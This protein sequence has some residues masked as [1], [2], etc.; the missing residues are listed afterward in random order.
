M[1]NMSVDATLTGSYDCVAV[2][3][4]VLTMPTMASEKKK[5]GRPRKYD[6]SEPHG[7]EGVNCNFYIPVELAAAMKRYRDA[8]EVKPDKSGVFRKAMEEFFAKR[9]FWSPS[10]DAEK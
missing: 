2:S 6:V 5:R 3:S 1:L 4:G 10:P 8:Q 9:G 7:R